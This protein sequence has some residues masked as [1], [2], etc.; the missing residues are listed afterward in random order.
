MQVLGVTTDQLADAMHKSLAP[1]PHGCHNRTM[2]D[3]YYVQQ[4]VYHEDGT[5]HLQQTFIPHTMTKGCEWSKTHNSERCNGC[6]HKGEQNGM[7]K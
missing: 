2:A 5:Y 4:R 7:A 3:G 6:I 1:K